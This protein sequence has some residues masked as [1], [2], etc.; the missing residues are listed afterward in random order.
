MTYR[1]ERMRVLLFLGALFLMPMLSHAEGCGSI[2]GPENW[3]DI[4]S[5]VSTPIENCDNPFGETTGVESPYTLDINGA[6][7]NDGDS[8]L[9]KGGEIHEYSTNGR[10]SGYMSV[11]HFLFFHDGDDYQFVD[12][13]KS[14]PTESDYRMLA[15]KFFDAGTDIEPF[16]AAMLD[17]NL[18]RYMDE[19]TQTLF[20]EFTDYVDANFVSQFPSLN[21]GTYTFVAREYELMLTQQNFIQQFFSHIVPTAYAQEEPYIFTITF[22][23]VEVP[24]TPT[25]NSN[26]LFLPGIQASRLYTEIDGKEEKIWEP[27]GNEDFDSLAMNGSGES[28]HDVYTKD[29]I[30]E[31]YGFSSMSIYKKFI[32]FLNELDGDKGPMVRTFP[33]DWRHDVF[34]IVE[35]GTKDDSGLIKKP[36]ETIEY[37]ATL[38][39]TKKVTII[40]HSNGGLFAKAIML[41]L[42]EEGKSHLIDKVIF[43]GTP[44]IGTPKALATV[45]HGYDQEHASGIISDDAVARRVMKN[46]PGV[47]GLLPSEVYV[48]SLSEPLISFDD[49]ELT[50]LFRNKY[51]F[52]VTNLAEYTDF[53]NGAEGR[54]DAGNRINEP[55]KANTGMLEKALQRHRDLDTWTAPHGVEV[56]NIIGTGLV[57]PKSIEYKAFDGVRCYVGYRCVR[58]KEIE[59]VLSFSGYGDQTVMS[60]SASAV[61][62]INYYVDLYTD[63]SVAHGNFT[64]ANTTQTLID[65]LLHGSSTNNINSV[66]QVEPTSNVELEVVSIHSPARIYLRD[67]SGNVTGKTTVDGKWLMEIEGSTYLEAGNVKYA[68]VPKS[69]S[70][71][72]IIEG[73]GS[74][75]FTTVIHEL[76][77]DVENEVHRFTA[78]TSSTTIASFEKTSEKFSPVSIDEDGNGVIDVELTVDGVII[79]KPATYNN[80]KGV[81]SS[82]ALP[83]IHK[84]ILLQFVKSAES[85]HSMKKNKIH[86]QAEKVLLSTLD[87]TVVLYER[88]KLISVTEAE[89]IR[90]IINSLILQIVW[91]NLK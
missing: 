67:S 84:E 58:E 56:H 14:Q 62:G 81:I 37:L 83:K 48:E 24:P 85:L 13:N 64:E 1:L 33:Y 22:T 79:E 76:H 16:I 25:G 88:K 47:Y 38:S 39:P 3:F 75:V 23:I 57:T 82:L 4:K 32:T 7:V 77:D 70:Y 26:I 91:E 80:L 60:K 34:D 30:D 51:G 42:E 87:K 89:K 5:I 59:P 28:V 41:K 45:L 72:A 50:S 71:E 53:L 11:N 18:A 61:V 10:S 69:T 74:G 44:H 29:V 40:A 27:V 31:L 35:N 90:K 52:T 36:I 66:S 17:R 9:A 43:I 78:T 20:W 8:V 73:E 55:T 15:Q 65:H 19:D 21:A 46:M 68:I 86:A 54:V 49:S 12:M 6:R 2:I 63:N